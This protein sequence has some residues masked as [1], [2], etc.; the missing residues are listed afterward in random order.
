M[1]RNIKV[2]ILLILIYHY[3]CQVYVKKMGQKNSK[4]N[5][6]YENFLYINEA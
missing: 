6:G 2:N 3:R 5:L 1:L 4:S